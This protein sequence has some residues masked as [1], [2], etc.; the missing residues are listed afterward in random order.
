MKSAGGIGHCGVP[1]APALPGSMGAA[2]RP[3]WLATAAAARRRE[4]DGAAAL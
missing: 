1:R 4:D 2:G 3:V